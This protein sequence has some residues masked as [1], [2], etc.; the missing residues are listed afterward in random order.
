VATW[1][2]LKFHLCHYFDRKETYTST[3]NRV[4]TR[5]WKTHSEKFLDYA[6]DKLKLMQQLNVS[7]EERIELL[8]DDIKPFLRSLALGFWGDSVPDFINYIRKISEANAVRRPGTEARAS[9]KP[10][11][12]VIQVRRDVL[13]I[14][15]ILLRIAVFRDFSS[16]FKCGRPGHITS[17]QTR[18]RHHRGHR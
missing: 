12:S 9:E 1:E 4:S 11:F 17:V 16:C 6:E 2:E 13:H 14:R 5:I 8:A 7:E 3:L 10:R 18:G 15:V